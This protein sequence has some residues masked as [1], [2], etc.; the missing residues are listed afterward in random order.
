MFRGL[1]DG[2][3]QVLTDTNTR[4]MKIEPMRWCTTSG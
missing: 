3:V 4:H 1:D 2:T